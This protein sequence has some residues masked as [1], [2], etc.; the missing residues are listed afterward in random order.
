MNTLSTYGRLVSYVKPYRGRLI[1]G[2]LA[3]VLAGGS[4]FG[5][6]TVIPNIIG[7]FTGGDKVAASETQG[8]EKNDLEKLAER[9]DIPIERED[10]SMSWQFMLLSMIGLPLI[11]LFKSMATYINRYCMRWVGA[12]VVHDLRNELFLALQNRSL[13]FWGKADVGETISRSTNDTQ[14]VQHAVATTI[15]DLSRAP[16]EILAAIAYVVYAAIKQDLL[17]VTAALIVVVPLCIVPVVIL[18]KKVKKYS[19]KAMERISDIVSRMHET[20]TGIRIVKACHTEAAESERFKNINAKYFRQ[21]LKALRAELLMTP[22]ME[23]VGILCACF[24]LAYAY[25]IHVPMSTIVAMSAAAVLC[26]RPIKQIAKINNQI[27]RS[28]ASAERIFELLDA[29]EDILEAANAQALADFKD[30]IRFS[31]V[32]FAYN[33]G[34]TV[35]QDID[36]E[37]HK[38]EFVAFVGGTGS[39]KTTL[40]NLL[41]RFYDPLRGSI[42]VDGIDLRDIQIAS[43]R[44]LIGIVTQDTVLFHDT[45]AANIAYG[46]PDATMDQIREAARLADAADFIESTIGGY[47][48][49]GGDKGF[50]FSGGQKQRISIARN[51]LRNPQILILDEAT[52]A[53]DTATEQQVH[54]QLQQLMSNRTVFAIAHRLSTVK[55]AD[56]IYVLHEGRIVETGTHEVLIAQGGRYRMLHDLQ[57]GAQQADAT[58]VT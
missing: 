40:A 9:F 54:K 43:L 23:M 57:F 39:G 18:G 37:I 6:L 47:D 1:A 26:Y 15:A 32:S 28:T 29:D 21:I 8:E 20:F 49:I 33:Q 27:Q 44:K 58:A 55:D 4:I 51:I 35:L 42:T 22:L 13:R 52:S 53:L 34:E 38:G 46:T 16:F 19:R 30:C 41:A 31:K 10:G 24:F 45:I 50:Q 2:I 36:I 17:G 56:R 25:A 12:R 7:P 5:I 14:M 11:M 48:K 3:G